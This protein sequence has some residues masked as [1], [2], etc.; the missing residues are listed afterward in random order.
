MS[1]VHLPIDIEEKLQILSLSRHEPKMGIIKEALELLL[2]S[3]QEERDSYEIG[4]TLFGRHG[5][6]GVSGGYK[7]RV[8]DK[9]RAKRDSR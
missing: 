3:E 5:S 4:K 2:K 8:K 6:G 1:T 7:E 9:I